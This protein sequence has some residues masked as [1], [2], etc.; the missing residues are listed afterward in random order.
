MCSLQERIVLDIVSGSIHKDFWR[1]DLKKQ[2]YKKFVQNNLY[3]SGKVF[4]V[5]NASD[6]SISRRL[7]ASFRVSYATVNKI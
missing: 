7:G 1:M 6:R 5:E 3:Y 4:I 2:I